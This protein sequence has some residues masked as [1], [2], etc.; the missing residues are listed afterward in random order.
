MADSDPIS[1]PTPEKRRKLDNG[2]FASTTKWDQDDEFDDND[3]VAE[4][5]ETQ[6]TMPI[7]TGQKRK[8]GLTREQFH[9]GMQ[10][11]LPSSNGASSPLNGA[12]V[13][14]PTQPL[15]SKSDIQVQRSSPVPQD[16][17]SQSQSQPKK[18]P[19]PAAR[20][21]LLANAMAP[22]GTSFRRPAGVQSKPAP[23]APIELDSDEEDPPVHHSSDE[24]TQGLKSNIKPTNFVKNGRGLDSSPN[25]IKESPRAP[26]AAPTGFFSSLM[27]QFEHKPNEPKP[28]NDM[29]SAYGGVSRKPKPTAA[30]VSRPPTSASA[31]FVTLDDVEDYNM[32]DKIRHIWNVLGEE[33][34]PIAKCMDALKR[35]HGHVQD[36]MGYLVEQQEKEEEL[37]EYKP[38]PPKG[39]A[40]GLAKGV[41]QPSSSS[42]AAKPPPKLASKQSVTA[43]KQSIA[44]RYAA[45]A[46]ARKTQQEPSIEIPDDDEDEVAAQPKRR[47]LKGRKPDRTPTPPSSPVP[48]SKPAQMKPVEQLKKK[49]QVIDLSEES[50]EEEEAE[51]SGADD[52]DAEEPAAAAPSSFEEKLLKFFNECSV[53]D[54][55]DLST[56]SEE[57]AKFLLDHRPFSS[58][59]AVREVTKTT[60][61]K[62]GKKS[63]GRAIG[64]KMVEVC[65]QMMGG[66]VAVDDL[67]EQCKVIGQPIKDA[68]KEWGV[69]SNE[70]E[71]SITNLDEAHDSGVGTPASS[72]DAPTK[73]RKVKQE[74]LRQPANMNLNIPLK[75]YQL[76]GLNW[77]DLL[78]SKRLACILAD[79]M[80]LGKTCQV[81]AFLAHLQQ[82]K[83]DGV[84]LIIVPGVTLE[85][86][87]RE[88]ARFAP[89]LNVTPYYGSQKERVELQDDIEERFCELDVIVTTYD[90][91]VKPDDNKFLK[92]LGPAVCVYDEAHAL[93][94]PKSNRYS[95]LT[96][97]PA[98]FKILLTGTP[99]QNNLQEL[100]AILAFIMPK[101]FTDKAEDL[102]FIFKHKATTKDTDHAALLSAERVARARSMMT[103]FIL[104]RKKAQ[105]LGNLP[106]KHSRVEYCD[107][108]DT[109]AN[110][111]ADILDGAQ[112]IFADKA[113]G[114]L[115]KSKAN[116][117]SNVLMELRKAAIHPLVS[118]RLY[119]D[120]KLRKIQTA[121]LKHEEFSSN[122]ADKVWAYLTGEAAVSLS[123]GDF[124][125]HRFCA[126][127]SDY[128]SK[129][130]LKNEEWMDSGKVAKLKALLATYVAN[131]DKVLLFS[132]FTMVMDVLEAVLETLSIK[133]MRLDGSTAINERQ[134]MIDKF[135]SDDTI[136]VFMLSTKAGG[137]GI[138]LAAANKVVIF[139]SGFNPQDDVQAENRAH[140][141]GQLRDVEVVRL[142]SRHTIEEQIYA[143]GESKLALDERVAG[144]AGA[145]GV[146][147]GDE[148]KIEGKGQEMVEE[149]MMRQAA[150]SGIKGEKGAGDLKDAFRK[151]LEGAGLEVGE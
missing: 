147:V 76:V 17:P 146:A 139:D 131:N 127:R 44:E 61:T 137:A 10:S 120:A 67:V 16:A 116:E 22:P 124:G 29:A 4:D 90:M 41:A 5:F 117:S 8:L 134:D 144:E 14:Q 119:T 99:L 38:P 36:A 86:W 35:K 92:R 148:K 81:I 37:P 71:L 46:A 58:L 19:A 93:R 26:T 141:V 54:L 18:A 101:L 65:E 74:F 43:P 53:R 108:T 105:V 45:Q 11:L 136:T 85:N 23:S 89:S 112:K 126:E 149:M 111:Y 63:R 98:D 32:R 107:M 87:L 72:C 95:Q 82:Q 30:P 70:G 129:Y 12:H 15:P 73:S 84:H 60:E 42:Q 39:I 150:S 113:A 62:S 68:L 118:R 79:D 97:I 103:P 21:S 132:Q 52:S 20:T 55:A 96:R 135:S 57:T 49:P 56:Q 125:L 128:L 123:G 133:F 102:E 40:R 47:L 140:R 110:Y 77:L 80:G 9:D 151:G 115:K 25:R 143:L 31:R 138:N 145:V 109:Q 121:L 13:T 50:D 130:M 104:R 1:E 91:A 114:K 64:D 33:K 51:E 94:N 69:A 78:W 28:S 122:P 6:P 88:F 27:S 7:S 59:D 24:E 106:A 100:V 3:L 75:D 2:R 66:Y 142:V 34:A 48:K 83:V